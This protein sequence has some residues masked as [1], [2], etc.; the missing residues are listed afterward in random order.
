MLLSYIS[1]SESS[2]NRL[3][4]QLVEVILWFPPIDI[5]GGLTLN[6]WIQSGGV[7]ISIITYLLKGTI[8]KKNLIIF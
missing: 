8:R 1:K 6:R 3:I 7:S 4:Y 5:D 2:V